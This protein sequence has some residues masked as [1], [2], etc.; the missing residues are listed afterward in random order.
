MIFS[1]WIGLHRGMCDEAMILRMKF[2]S[3]GENGEFDE[4]FVC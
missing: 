2:E 3:C 1:R 4:E